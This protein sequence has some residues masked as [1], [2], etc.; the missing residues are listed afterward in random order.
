MDALKQGFQ[1][2]L[3]IEALRMFDEKEIEVR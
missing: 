3:S 1:E 2:I